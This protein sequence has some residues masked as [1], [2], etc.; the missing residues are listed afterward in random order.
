ML[1]TEKDYERVLDTEDDLIKLFREIPERNIVFAF[2]GKP[3][4]IVVHV[5][6]QGDKATVREESYDVLKS[7]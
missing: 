2:T 1:D 6:R 5:I 3:F 4:P 7:M